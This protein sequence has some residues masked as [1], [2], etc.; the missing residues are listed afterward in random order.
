MVAPDSHGL[1]EPLSRQ[2]YVPSC[3]TTGSPPSAASTATGGCSEGSEG[4]GASVGDG[5]TLLASVAAG[6]LGGVDTAGLGGVWFPAGDE[7]AAV[8]MA[9]ANATDQPAADRNQEIVRRVI[10][11]S[12]WVYWLM[13][14]RGQLKV[15]AATVTRIVGLVSPRRPSLVGVEKTAR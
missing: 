7:Q 5:D 11:L 2:M 6:A 13:I 4:I 14:G 1:S 3:P 8:A 15:H 9:T 12:Y 10:S